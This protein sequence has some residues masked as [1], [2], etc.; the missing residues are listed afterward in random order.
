MVFSSFQHVLGFWKER[1]KTEQPITYY[2]PFLEFHMKSENRNQGFGKEAKEVI[3]SENLHHM[4][5]LK[6]R[7]KFVPSV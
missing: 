6:K 2:F 7:V 4:G 5:E 1:T 3:P